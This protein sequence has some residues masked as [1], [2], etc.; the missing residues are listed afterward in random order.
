MLQSISWQEFLTAI[1]L[2]LG[3]YYT[4][5][6]LLLYSGEIKSIFKQKKPNS[7]DES[8]STDQT[9]SNEPNDLMGK[10]KY[11]T[12]VNVP[13]EK[14]VDAEDVSVINS[15]EENLKAHDEAEESIIISIPDTPETTLAKA[16]SQLL[17]QA[18]SIL[19]EFPPRDKEEALLAFSSLFAKFPQLVGTNFQD[20]VSELIHDALA[21]NT[22]IQFDLNDVKSWWT[23]ESKN[24]E[25]N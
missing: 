14:S 1:S 15:D 3:T 19:A 24:E 11:T 13:H 8:S 7:I 21:V 20:E 18:K 10:V 4:I 25:I 12:T 22:E 23:D 2:I 16:V 5:S 17:N 9:D 6:T